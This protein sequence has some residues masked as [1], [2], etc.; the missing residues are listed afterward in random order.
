MQ[1]DSAARGWAGGDE[2]E[3]GSLDRKDRELGGRSRLAPSAIAALGIPLFASRKE[4][5]I[6][7]TPKFRISSRTC[8]IRFRI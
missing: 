1:Q 6:F 4:G 7:R 2:E 3:V 5:K 8:G